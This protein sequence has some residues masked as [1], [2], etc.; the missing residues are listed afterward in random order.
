[1]SSH[2]SL[3]YFPDS[4]P[5]I[6]RERRG[7]GFS[8]IA[9]DGSRVPAGP[10][11][12]RIDALAIPPAYE[13]VWI[14]P[15]PNARLLATGFDARGRKQYRY[16]PLWSEAQSETKFASLVEF[17]A[18]L[19]AIRRRV[20]RDLTL[21]PGQERFAIAAAVKLID[22]LSLRVGNTFYARENDSYG[23]L[24][25]K[26]RH[27]RFSDGGIRL[28]FK[29]KGGKR[30]RRQLADSSLM[31]ILEKIRHLPGAELLSWIDD[32]GTPHCVSSTTLNEYLCDAGGSDGFSAKTF[33]TW[34]GTVAAFTVAI[35]QDKPTIKKM[36]EAA[37][38][39]LHN[40]PTIAR[41]SY[42]HPDVIALTESHPDLPPP[43]RIAGL[44]LA[45]RRLLAYLKSTGR[46]QEPLRKSA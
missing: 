39:R 44:V 38:K 3:Q 41:K 22:R 5:G 19:P 43:E 11:R 14:A 20:H 9:P 12:D 7:R 34:A 31:K 29:S 17:G 23:A 45:E 24:T 46:K 32:E 30:V 33:R 40:T 18:A 16:H 36:A 13:N 1:M 2:G 15:L 10:E 25:L 26:R 27:V 42:I 4:R 35:E 21:D 28:S 6:R 8:Y 37:A